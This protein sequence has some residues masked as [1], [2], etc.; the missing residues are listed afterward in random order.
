[1]AGDQR[2]EVRDR[3]VSILGR[4]AGGLDVSAGGDGIVV[5]SRA[6]APNGEAMW[7]GAVR[8]GKA[9]VSYHFMPV[10]GDPVL[11]ESISPQLRRRMQGKSCFNFTKVDDALFEELDDLTARGIERYRAKGYLDPGARILRD[12]SVA[13]G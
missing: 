3:L 9:Y 6:V 2:A 1:M 7:V 5:R 13:Q 4:H 8:S 11:L 12:G 10:Y